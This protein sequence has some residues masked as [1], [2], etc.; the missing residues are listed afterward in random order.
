MAGFVMVGD[1]VRRIVSNLRVANENER[2]D[3]LDA[4]DERRSQVGAIT[5]RDREEDARVGSGKGCLGAEG[6]SAS[7]RPSARGTARSMGD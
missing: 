4:A 2:P 1:V 3:R 6:L 5:T 7:R